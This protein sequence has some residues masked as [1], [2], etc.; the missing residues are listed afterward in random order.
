[1]NC[2]TSSYF[3]V[4]VHGASF[5]RDEGIIAGVR[6]ENDMRGDGGVDVIDVGLGGDNCSDS[7]VIGDDTDGE[8]NRRSDSDVLKSGDPTSGMMDISSEYADVLV[9]IQ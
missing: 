5:A 7:N 1:M 3:P 8:G 4:N 2:L 9:G 6:M